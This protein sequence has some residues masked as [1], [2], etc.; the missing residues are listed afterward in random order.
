M[1]IPTG[2]AGSGGALVMF[3]ATGDLARRKLFPALYHLERR[4]RL[5]VPVVGVARSIWD[6]A[7]FAE[8]AAEAIRDFVKDPAPQ[9]VAARCARLSLVRGEYQSADT[10]G[11][12]RDDLDRLDAAVPV[13]Y[14]AIPPSAFP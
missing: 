4:G 8:H 9:V 11:L 5:H 14:L 2:P 3:G 7:A 10:F 13:Y 12:L 6:D 1:T